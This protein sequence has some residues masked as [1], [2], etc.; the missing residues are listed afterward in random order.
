[1]NEN[2]ESPELFTVREIAKK[3]KCDAEKVS[4][5]FAHEKG[6]IDIGT[7]GDVR[8]RIKPYRMLR[9]PSHVLA[10]VERKWNPN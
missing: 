5:M 1:M 6:V 7:R 8:K 2:S 4:K 10:A 9:I 3:W